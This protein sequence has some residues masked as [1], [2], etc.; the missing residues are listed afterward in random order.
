MPRGVK[1]VVPENEP[2]YSDLGMLGVAN[3][4]TGK[5]TWVIERQ[6]IGEVS[7]KVYDRLPLENTVDGKTGPVEYSSKSSAQAFL[8]GY[9]YAHSEMEEAE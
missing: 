7:G 3:R 2:R 8:D 4:K 9:T 5:T 1:N 6:A